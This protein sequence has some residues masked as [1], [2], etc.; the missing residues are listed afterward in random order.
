MQTDKSIIDFIQRGYETYLPHISIDCAVFGFYE[1]Q[2]K[3][4]LIQWK[5]TGKWSLPGG[6]IQRS[7]SVDEAAKRI[8]QERTGLE[9]IFLEQFKLFGDANR[10][11][12]PDTQTIIQAA[13]TGIEADNWLLQR[14]VSIG[15]YALVDFSRTK[16]TPD[17]L[18]ED[19]RW[20][21]IQEMPPLLFDHEEIVKSA[22]KALRLQ[23]INQPV[24]YN[25]LPEK[26]TMSQL[27]R[28]YETILD[29]TIDRRNFEKKML[30]LGILDRLDEVK[31]DV[32]YKAPMLYRFNQAKYQGLL[33]ADFGFGF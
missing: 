4:L 28:L 26:F 18:L 12:T 32:S 17:L 8:L 21:D 5:E 2:L 15:Y 10:K 14:M 22:L 11:N 25:L 31:S 33:N 1:N 30:K 20:W 13:G 27:R 24:G 3:I 9:N 7:E 29:K 6:F 23:L 16:P 19:C